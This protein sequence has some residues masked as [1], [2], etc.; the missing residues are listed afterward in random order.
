[1]FTLDECI[2]ESTKDENTSLDSHYLLAEW[3]YNWNFPGSAEEDDVT[4]EQLTNLHFVDMLD[5]PQKDEHLKVR[6][7]GSSDEVQTLRQIVQQ[8]SDVFEDLGRLPL[9]VKAMELQHRSGIKPVFIQRRPLRP[10]DE[11][12]LHYYV[13]KLEALGIL[14]QAREREWNSPV[15]MVEDKGKARKRFT[16]DYRG[17]NS[18]LEL[19]ASRVPT[20]QSL[21]ALTKDCRH[22]G[23]FDLT[24]YFFQIPLHESSQEQTAF[25]LPD[26]RRMCWTRCPMGVS[27]S[28]TYAQLIAT[29]LYPEEA[30]MDDVLLRGQTFEAFKS[31]VEMKLQTA[32]QYNLKLSAQKTVLNAENITYCLFFYIMMEIRIKIENSDI[33]TR[34]IFFN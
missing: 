30:F 34:C 29:K 8:Y 20:V 28:A 11:D 26:G 17:L 12:D 22:L 1:L 3:I 9:K 24:K 2:W 23:K 7:E 21:L 18:T 27:M 5:E 14:R 15:Y 4:P 13:N 25:T 33:F 19:V 31:D 16:I 32:R 6:V 10:A